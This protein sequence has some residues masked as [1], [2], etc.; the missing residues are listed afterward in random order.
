[1][2]P[3]RP[4]ILVLLVAVLAGCGRAPKTFDS[5]SV[6]PTATVPAARAGF[7][8]LER[9]PL[10]NPP[11]LLLAARARREWNETVVWNAVAVAASERGSIGTSSF[12]PNRTG[13]ATDL[14]PDYVI[15]RESGGDYGAY[16]PTGCGGRG[17]AGR[18][19]FDP[20]TWDAQAVAMGR[21]DLVGH[22]FDASPADQ[23]AVAR[24]TW[25][26]GAGCSHWAAC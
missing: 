9:R 21:P 18:Y 4:A 8:P 24:F 15:D 25:N 22:A 3:H 2:R 7:Q 19:Q 6:R 26:N 11:S 14:P 1:M 12:D 23:D 5:L 20:T 17:C 16:N 13:A 10:R